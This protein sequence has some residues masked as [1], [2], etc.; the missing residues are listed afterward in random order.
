MSLDIASLRKE[1]TKAELTIESVQREPLTQFLAWFDEAL[2]S[3]INEPT[4][5][6]LSCA[7][8]DGKPSSRVVLL[9][10]VD[11]EGFVWY[12]NYLSR[13]GSELDVNPHASLLFFWPELERQIR[14]EGVVTKV[15]QEQSTEY[16][17]SR[18][19][20]SQVGAAAS[21]QSQVV[22]SREF[23]ADLFSMMHTA[24]TNAQHVEKPPHWGGYKLVPTAI[25]FWQGR[26]SRMHDRIRYRS[27]NDQWII[28]RLAP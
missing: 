9:K 10:G 2:A 16:F 20:D 17:H 14:I 1:Y 21:P 22:P 25:E 12:T 4:A 3:D 5:M 8:P 19:F 15:S 11:E 28:E 23:L 26:P 13:K 6:V 24:A 7:T 27:D 18:P